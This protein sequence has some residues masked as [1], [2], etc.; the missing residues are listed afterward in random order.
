MQLSKRQNS[1]HLRLL[2]IQET[3]YFLRVEVFLGGCEWKRVLSVSGLVDYKNK[4]KYRSSLITLSL[5]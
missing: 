2:H 1:H 5:C 4:C 3:R